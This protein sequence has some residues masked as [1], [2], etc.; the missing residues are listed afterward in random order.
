MW[1]VKKNNNDEEEK[2]DPGKKYQEGATT[3]RNAH[4]MRPEFLWEGA[5]IW[6]VE[7]SGSDNKTP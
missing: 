1:L 3:S 4:G 2:D 7:I 6:N 5:W